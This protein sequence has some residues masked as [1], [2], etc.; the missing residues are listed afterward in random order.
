MQRREEGNIKNVIHFI[1]VVPTFRAKKIVLGL[2]LEVVVGLLKLSWTMVLLQYHMVSSHLP[3][4][5]K[6]YN[7]YPTPLSVVRI[8]VELKGFR[9]TGKLIWQK[10]IRPIVMRMV[11]Y[12]QE[13]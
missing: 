2:R 9:W 13:A 12:Y 3:W 1:K 7:L 5:T 8:L 11:R 4:Q 10:T 6:P